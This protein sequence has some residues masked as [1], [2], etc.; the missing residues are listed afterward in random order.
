MID[1][2]AESGS[3]LLSIADS[4]SGGENTE[5]TANHRQFGDLPARAW[6]RLIGTHSDDHARQLRRIKSHPDYPN[7]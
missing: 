6:F 5:V 3:N 1:A 4:V 2:Y 7:A